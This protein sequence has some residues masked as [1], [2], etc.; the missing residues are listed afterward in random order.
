VS[1]RLE[2]G[3]AVGGDLRAGDTV[4]V[5][6]TY[7]AGGEPQTST[8]SRDAVVVRVISDEERVGAGGSIVLVLAVRPDELEPIASAS[9]AGH[10]T[11][12]RTTGVAD[13]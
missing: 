7:T 9:T 3:A 6:V 5:I 11:I 12:A 13:R 4:D 2:P 8:I 10:V 1:M